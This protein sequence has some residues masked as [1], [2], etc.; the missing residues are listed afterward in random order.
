[1][2][3]EVKR[4]LTLYSSQ[5]SVHRVV[6]IAAQMDTEKCQR[7]TSWG[8]RIVLARFSGTSKSGGLLGL[9]E[10][11]ALVDT[12]NSPSPNAQST[13]P[14]LVH[15]PPVTA[16]SESPETGVFAQ[17]LSMAVAAW[18]ITEKTRDSK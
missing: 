18:W 14:Y 13:Y 17:A 15:T 9:R 1:M 11:G 6:G 10:D 2:I 3:P 16:G 7:Y 12:E 4:T 8:L 5:R